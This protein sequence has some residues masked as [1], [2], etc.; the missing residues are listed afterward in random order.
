MSGE[1][2]SLS[3]LGTNKVFKFAGM[4]SMYL[5]VLT[6]LAEVFHNLDLY[7]PVFGWMENH[8]LLFYFIYLLL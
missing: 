1:F 3:V 6:Q 2:S 5:T 7:P 4:D 8:Q